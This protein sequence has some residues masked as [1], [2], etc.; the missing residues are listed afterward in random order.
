MK[1]ASIVL[2]CLTVFFC[3]RPGFGQ[4]ANVSELASDEGIIQGFIVNITRKYVR[5]KV[6][7]GD[8]SRIRYKFVVNEQTKIVG[9]IAKGDQV[10]VIFAK[11]RIGRSARRARLIIPAVRIPSLAVK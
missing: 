4:Q 3:F 5:V 11:K 1:A 10:T 2:C 9:N 7:G 6:T 8:L